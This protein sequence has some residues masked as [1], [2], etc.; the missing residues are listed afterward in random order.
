[1]NSN[2][3]IQVQKFGQ[4]LWYDNIRRGIINSGELQRLIDD[5]GILGIT[6]NPTIFEKAITGSTD[7]DKALT[8]LLSKNPR[9]SVIRLYETL[10]IEDIQKA[11]DILS[12]IYERT[13]FVDGYVSVEVSPRLAYDTNRTIEEARKLFAVVNRPNVMIKVPATD[14]GLPA[15]T[16]LISEGI[17]VNVTL[18][19]SLQDFINVS[20]AYLSGLEKLAQS[21]G[22]LS[23]VASVAS[24]FVSRIDSAVDKLLPEDSPLRGKIAIA[25]AKM[26][27]SHFEKVYSSPRFAALKNKGARIQRLLWASTGTKNPQYSDVLY[28]E[29]LIGPNTVNT[30]PPTTLDA[31]R[32]FGRVSSRFSDTLDEAMELLE[33]LGCAG[34]DLDAVTQKLKNDGVAA[35]IKSFDSLLESLTCKRNSILAGKVNRQ[36]LNLGQYE[37]A[38]QSRL[39][40]WDESELSRRI[41]QKDGTVWIPDIEI[42]ARTKELTNR[43]GW[44][45]LPEVMY[46]ESV[47]L[48]EFA[49]EIKQDGFTDIVL[50]A[51]GGSSLAPEV[52][53][54][55]FGN[56]LGFP[57]LTVLDSTDPV[58]VKT[59]HDSID[60]AK[61]LFLVSS[62]SGGTIETLSFFKY[63]YQI[64]KAVKSD[65]GKNFVVLTDP[66]SKL[67]TLAKEKK[68]RRL[69]STPHDVG[70]RYSALTYFGLLPAALIGVDVTKILESAQAMLVSTHYCGIPAADNP[71]LTLGA[72]MG[73]LAK[74]GRDKI[75]F[76]I[77]PSITS[78]GAW[79]EQLVAEST[80]KNDTGILPVVDEPFG[81]ESNFGD[82][83]FFVYLRLKG[84][85]NDA[86]DKQFSI[87]ESDGHPVVKITLQNRYDLGG[88]FFRWELATAAAGA[89]LRINPFDQP[90][91]EAAKSKARGLMDAYQ[92]SGILPS[93]PPILRDGDIEIYSKQTRQFK[94]LEKTIH[95]FVNQAKSGDYLA[96]MTYVPR[97][98]DDIDEAL[99]GVRNLL[100][101][102]LKIA[103]TLGYGPRFLHSTGQLHKGDG[104]N[105]LFIQ[106]THSSEIDLDIP[107][108]AYSFGTLISA[109]AQGDFQALVDRGRRVIRFHI[110]GDV[111]DGLRRLSDILLKI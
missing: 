64:V 102:R 9:I 29:E 76:F 86:L 78:F 72:A 19:F 18:M 51:M 22:D 40:S 93:E 110:K 38:V 99:N 61:T 21:D 68:L 4:S 32:N 1:M 20:D 111:F 24:F 82:D 62:K 7:Y 34:I 36:K 54:Q 85:D 101:N 58:S 94:S 67:E 55:T 95:D 8:D 52:F 105:G 49:E 47:K 97:Y 2:P 50:L 39:E 42:A 108:E 46:E 106:I 13:S 15:I 73:E 88:E 84:D 27:Y 90:N 77:S 104:N 92:N 56:S 63:F 71:A 87:I 14:E 33:K 25:N 74:V 79:V 48:V 70:G 31:F 59:V 66:G 6:S 3:T 107:G 89:V 45:A 75:T 30:V 98:D 43:L 100:A 69:F 103:V 37:H 41:W 53:M 16:Q 10:V 109:Q 23:K 65:P 83:R 60:P 28:L 35:F 96:L 5:F 11:A 44:L 80:G 57:K 26:T 12:P 81:Y 91:V 17:N